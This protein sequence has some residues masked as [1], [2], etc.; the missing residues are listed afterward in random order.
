MASEHRLCPK[1][2]SQDKARCE[3]KALP[4]PE[5]W[6]VSKGSAP[7]KAMLE[8]RGPLGTADLT[9][10]QKWTHSSQPTDHL[11]SAETE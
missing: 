11:Y 4:V 9:D 8:H 10:E 2:K 5:A 7:T 6:A 3:S 1:T